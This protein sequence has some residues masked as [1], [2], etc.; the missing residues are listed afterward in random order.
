MEIIYKGTKYRIQKNKKGQTSLN[1]CYSGIADIEDIEGL[2]SLRELEILDLRGNKITEIKGLD[3][4]VNLKELHLSVN[5]ITDI[6]GLEKLNNLQKLNLNKNHI[7]QINGLE[8]L[9]NLEELQLNNNLITEITGLEKLTRLKKLEFNYN[10]INEISGLD[11]L[12]ELQKLEFNGNQINEIKGFNNLT[13]LRIIKLRHNNISAIRG[14]DNL[15]NLEELY[16]DENPVWRRA[17]RQ[18]GKS[19][20]GIGLIQDP[21]ALVKFCQKGGDTWQ[22]EQKFIAEN[23]KR[24]KYKLFLAFVGIFIMSIGPILIFELGLSFLGWITMIGGIGI[25][26]YFK[27]NTNWT[28]KH[29]ISFGV[30]GLIL[31]LVG[32]ILMVRGDSKGVII[33]IIGILW[34]VFCTDLY[35]FYIVY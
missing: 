17:K 20:Y 14:F 8:S 25:H 4:L 29:R 6:I 23:E 19:L 22:E 32:A 34:I 2:N 15:I 28:N 33:L 1:L 18:F 7:S 31:I 16:I 11:N 35:I 12:R 27:Y 21:Q 10:Q 24:L 30:L 3:N 9:V 26:L 13:N 5:R